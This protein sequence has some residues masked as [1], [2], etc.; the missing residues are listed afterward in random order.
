MV[1]IN[2]IKDSLNG[3]TIAETY[4]VNES[5]QLSESSV[6]A[7]QSLSDDFNDNKDIDN[8]KLS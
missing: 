5:G 6:K 2:D 7:S 3:K 4:S 1:S 8:I